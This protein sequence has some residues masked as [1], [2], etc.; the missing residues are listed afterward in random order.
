MLYPVKRYILFRIK[1]LEDYIQTIKRQREIAKAYEAPLKISVSISPQL[2]KFIVLILLSISLLISLVV[3]RK[4]VF[5]IAASIKH[6]IEKSI[7]EKKI[8]AEKDKL[9]PKKL[10]KKIIT[11]EKTIS[12]KTETK[13][14]KKSVKKAIVP[15]DKMK[16]FI[17]A[18]KASKEMFLLENIDTSWVVKYSYKVA[19]GEDPRRKLK[20][21]DLRT[22]EG[23]YFIVGRQ[24]G[25]E[26]NR[27]YGPLAYVLNYPN[28]EDKKAGRTGTGIWIHGT[29][30][31]TVPFQT[32][33]C[34]EMNNPEL[35]NL[36]QIL[37]KGIGTPVLIISDSTL[38]DLVNYPDYASILTKKENILKRYKTHKKEF[39][40]FLDTWAKAWSS[41]EI[42]KYKTLY[43][44]DRFSSRGMN[45]EA[46]MEYKQKTFENYS[47]IEIGINDFFLSDFSES[48]AVLKFVQDYKSNRL[49]SVNGKRL[50]LI[51]RKD[52]WKI[53][54]ETSIPKEELLL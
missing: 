16:Y 24:E 7:E 40:E 23:Q 33:G 39:D 15:I 9:K 28:E 54:S 21:G 32:K 8:A 34:L 19:I 14:Q 43:D 29:A 35:S 6:K 49:E 38:T 26:L 50:T 47:S 11:Q 51:K 12:K 46:W 25:N 41:R 13:K 10:T 4:P 53:Y 42:D 45:W 1:E 2:V 27:I 48:T 20:E 18:N 3:F 36:S 5:N 17:L 31:D 30:P 44:K 37:K 52:G 22:P